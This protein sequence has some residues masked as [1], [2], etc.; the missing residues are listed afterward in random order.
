M[1]PTQSTAAPMGTTYD[2]MR[3]QMI[4]ALLM[5]QM[6][7]LPAVA[8][9]RR[10]GLLSL[11]NKPQAPRAYDPLMDGQ[12]QPTQAQSLSYLQRSAPPVDPVWGS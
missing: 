12:D 6:P 5:R 3:Q 1:D 2:P 7:A 9:R 11:G 4:Q 8:P 10:S